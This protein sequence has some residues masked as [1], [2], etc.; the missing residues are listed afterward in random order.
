MTIVIPE[1]RLKQQ[2]DREWIEAMLAAVQEH[3]MAVTREIINGR[4]PNAI[5]TSLPAA[6]KGE[7]LWLIRLATRLGA[8]RRSMWLSTKTASEAD[9]MAV[10][11]L[12]DAITQ[13]DADASSILDGCTVGM[14]RDPATME[15]EDR[16]EYERLLTLS[17]RAR[18]AMTMLGIG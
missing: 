10:T 3:V 8:M 9:A 4:E 5:V 13:I 6:S 2:L 12:Y 14:G 7:Y 17:K 15:A 11:A 16:E 18:C 1:P